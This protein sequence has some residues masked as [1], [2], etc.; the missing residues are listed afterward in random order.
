MKVSCLHYQLMAQVLNAKC[1]SC[2]ADTLLSLSPC[3]GRSFSSLSSQH[4]L[5][6]SVLRNANFL[7]TFPRHSPPA[8]VAQFSFSCQIFFPQEFNPPQT[9]H[10][11][12]A[13]PTLIHTP[14]LFFIRSCCSRAIQIW[15]LFNIGR[16]IIVLSNLLLFVDIL[17]VFVLSFIVLEEVSSLPSDK[18][19]PEWITLHIAKFF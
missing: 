15:P 5:S 16:F 12:T 8:C 2:G 17:F 18:D 6:I 9:K 10:P 19:F 13:L 7:G 3:K 4:L 11:Q 1:R 14:S